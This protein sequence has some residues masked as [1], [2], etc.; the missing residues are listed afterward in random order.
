M[1]QSGPPK[2]LER[3]VEFLLPS[4]YREHVLGDLYERYQS[5]A[6]YARDAF[7][8]APR[9]I[10]CHIR[11][12]FAPGDDQ[13]QTA[14]GSRGMSISPEDVRRNADQLRAKALRGTLGMLGTVVAAAIL[15]GM[16]FS[17]VPNVTWL[18]F[19]VAV[20]LAV[21]VYR[22][23]PGPKVPPDATLATAIDFYRRELERQ[24]DSGRRIWLWFVAPM[25][26]LLVAPVLL[27]LWTSDRAISWWS[28]A[29]FVSLTAAWALTMVWLTQQEVK[30]IQREI[31]D[32]D[33]P[34]KS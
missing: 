21:Q 34:G 6:Q 29:P 11:R 16:T 7:R 1:M 12:T 19:A 17:K 14:G 32:L 24:R 10:W 27:L 33:R 3:V 28:V 30:R 15:I 22:K 5:P 4:D 9:V 23:R 25:L 8:T 2:W 13:L 18:V 31:D 26:A 20:F